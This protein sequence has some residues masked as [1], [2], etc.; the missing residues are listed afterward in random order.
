MKP[1]DEA[2]VRGIVGICFKTGVVENF[3]SVGGTLVITLPETLKLE[4]DTFD[5][6]GF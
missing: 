6:T 3:I 4:V 5:E 2:D 1:G